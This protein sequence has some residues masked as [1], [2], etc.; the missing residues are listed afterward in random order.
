ML[1][2]RADT[3]NLGEIIGDNATWFEM[4]YLENALTSNPTLNPLASRAPHDVYP[5]IKMAEVDST[6]PV[7]LE[8]NYSLDELGELVGTMKKLLRVRDILLAV[9]REY[10]RS[11][12]QSDDYRTEP[13]FQLQGSYR[14]MNRIAERVS[15]LMNEG[16]LR[17]LIVSQYEQDAQTLTSGTE[18]NLLKFKELM[19]ILTETETARW[20]D[21][22][23]TFAQNVK[24]R[25]FGGDDRFAQI[26]GQM[27]EFSV[28]LEAIRGALAAGVDRLNASGN[29]DDKN[30]G[31]AASAAV[32]QLAR[33]GDHLDALQKAVTKGV[34]KIA[35][36]PASPKS[37]S[38]TFAP[39]TAELLTKFIAE[40]QLSQR[41]PAQPASAGGAHEVQSQTAPAE[42]GA[43]G[44][45]KVHVVNKVPRLFLS[46]IREQFHLMQEW[47]V[48]LMEVSQKNREGLAELQ[49][50]LDDAMKN[51]DEMIE[52]LEDT[53]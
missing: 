28:G 27:G 16:E 31:A 8:G 20:N 15:P 41:P 36:P 38:A 5:L 10:I 26:V 4:S 35:K 30:S 13:P 52:R 48:P 19:Q 53:E 2:N 7:D 33:F 9:N 40:L 18:A 21:I 14:N 29:A 23:K 11:A 24:L 25:S 1:A 12:G 42:A 3:Y 44:P 46:I 39:E 45:I 34:T 17:S 43:A 37:V 32:T 50:Q 47:M 49:S 6:D 22:K 51:Y